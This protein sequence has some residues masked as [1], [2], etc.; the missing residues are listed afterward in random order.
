M[1]VARPRLRGEM[2]ECCGMSVGEP[3]TETMA[4]TV[5][6]G[7]LGPVGFLWLGEHMARRSP[8]AKAPPDR[9]AERREEVE[10][11]QAKWGGRKHG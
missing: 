9:R 2:V 1:T 6:V 10:A 3:V 4:Q 8:L 5:Q 11:L 7:Q